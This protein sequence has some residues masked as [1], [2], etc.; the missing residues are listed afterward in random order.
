MA[1]MG[2]EGRKQFKQVGYLSAVGL[3]VA[4]STVVGLFAGRWLDGKLGTDPFLM[5]VG[6]VLGVVAGFRSVYRSARKV[7][8]RQDRKQ[9]DE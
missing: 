6:L 5:I 2:P 8:D 3:E 9:G 7:M 4:V 1:L